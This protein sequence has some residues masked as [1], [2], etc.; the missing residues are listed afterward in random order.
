[1]VIGGAGFRPFTVGPPVVPFSPLVFFWF[2][3]FPY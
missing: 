3:G 1:M 2:G